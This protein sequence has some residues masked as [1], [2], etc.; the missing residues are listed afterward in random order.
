MIFFVG[1]TC[2]S[3][4]YERVNLLDNRIKVFKI[5]E[6]ENMNMNMN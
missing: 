1:G 3:E 6:E 4:R 5:S 2:M